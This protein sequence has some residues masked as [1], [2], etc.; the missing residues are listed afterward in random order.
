MLGPE[1]NPT[2]FTLIQHY[3]ASFCRNSTDHWRNDSQTLVLG[4]DSTFQ[5]TIFPFSPT[6]I[7]WVVSFSRCLTLYSSIVSEIFTIQAQEDSVFSTGSKRALASSQAPRLSMGK[8]ECFQTENASHWIL[9]A[10][11]TVERHS[12]FEWAQYLCILPL[13]LQ[14][15]LAPQANHPQYG[16]L[17]Q[18]RSARFV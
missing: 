17:L 15:N 11:G 8:A 7:V 5:I 10:Q 14:H 2:M 16:S 18:L 4:L 9:S 12:I 6:A 1:P 13:P 3:H